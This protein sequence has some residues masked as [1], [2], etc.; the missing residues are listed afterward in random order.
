MKRQ[1]ELDGKTIDYDLER[2]NVMN[3]N[4]RFL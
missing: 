1:I 2:K 3:L 4:L